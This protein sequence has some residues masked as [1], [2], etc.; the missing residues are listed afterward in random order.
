MSKIAATGYAGATTL[1]CIAGGP[2]SKIP[3]NTRSAEE[4][5]HDAFVAAER[6]SVMRYEMSPNISVLFLCTDNFTRSVTAEFCLTDYLIKRDIKSIQVASAGTN[7]ASDVSGFITSHFERMR[8]RGF[9]TSRFKRTQ[10]EESFF[11][12]YDLIVGMGPEHRD[13]IKQKYNR[14]ILLLNDILR[15]EKYNSIVNI[16]TDDLFEFSVRL[17]HMVDYLYD[18]MPRFVED[19]V[20]RKKQK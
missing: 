6:L 15:D 19:M 10:F 5:L 7:A 8:E 18:A 12:T 4:W 20:I 14:T 2:G 3:N 16:Q 13:Y 17:R 9:D 1:E 11:D